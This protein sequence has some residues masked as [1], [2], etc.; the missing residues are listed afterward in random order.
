MTFLHD[1][2]IS[3]VRSLHTL[4]SLPHTDIAA[5]GSDD[6]AKGVGGVKYAYTVELRDEGY[7]GFVLPA[8]QIIPTGEET[9]EAVLVVGDF[10]R[11]TYGK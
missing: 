5:G 6:W 8:E 7:Y 11:T 2:L 3:S 1:R 4:D 9:L 10:V